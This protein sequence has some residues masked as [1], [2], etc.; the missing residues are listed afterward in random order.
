MS[1]LGTIILI[2]LYVLVVRLANHKP[3]LV[4]REATPDERQAIID[5]VKGYKPG[6]TTVEIGGTTFDLMCVP[7]DDF[8]W[9]PTYAARKKARAFT[10]ENTDG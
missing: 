5:A 6:D 4:A 2:G 8:D 1:I 9:K 3:T 7:P 10:P